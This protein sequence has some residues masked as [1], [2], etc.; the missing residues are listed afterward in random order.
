MP[1]VS[2]LKVP[3]AVH[4][5]VEIDFVGGNRDAAFVVVDRRDNRRGFYHV[6][7][8]FRFDN[9]TIL[10]ESKSMCEESVFSAPVARVILGGNLLGG[11]LDAGEKTFLGLLLPVSPRL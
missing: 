8:G 9:K 2:I 10:S 3:F 6:A 1:L 5:A 11:L 4:N 7:A